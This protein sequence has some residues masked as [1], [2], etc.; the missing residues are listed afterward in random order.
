MRV[1]KYIQNFPLTR[2]I[3]PNISGILLSLEPTTQSMFM[4]MCVFIIEEMTAE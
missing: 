4:C 1:N 2:T 3:V